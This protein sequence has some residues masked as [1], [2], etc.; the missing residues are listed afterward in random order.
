MLFFSGIMMTDKDGPI[1][2][3]ESKKREA[4]DASERRER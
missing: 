3:Q 2:R 4:Q 1:K